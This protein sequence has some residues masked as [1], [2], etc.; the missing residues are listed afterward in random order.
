MMG[1]DLQ[2]MQIAHLDHILDQYCNLKSDFRDLQ[3]TLEA[4]VLD[5]DLVTCEQVLSP[6]I[7]QKLGDIHD[8]LYN[9][10]SG[11]T[12]FERIMEARFDNVEDHLAGAT[13]VG[14]RKDVALNDKRICRKALRELICYPFLASTFEENLR[15]L[16]NNETLTKENA[17]R[18]FSLPVLFFAHSAPQ[19]P[20]GIVNFETYILEGRS[21]YAWHQ[22]RLRECSAALSYAITFLKQTPSYVAS[23]CTKRNAAYAGATLAA[24]AIMFICYQYSAELQDLIAD[25]EIQ[26]G[27][28]YAG[29]WGM[30]KLSHGKTWC[31]SWFQPELPTCPWISGYLPSGLEQQFQQIPPTNPLDLLPDTCGLFDECAQCDPTEF[32]NQISNLQYQLSHLASESSATITQLQA[33][34]A[35]L[36]SQAPACNAVSCV[37]I[38]LAVPLDVLQQVA[39]MPLPAIQQLAQTADSNTTTQAAQFIMRSLQALKNDGVGLSINET[40]VHFDVRQSSSLGSYISSCLK[41]LSDLLSITA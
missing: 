15:E 5:D 40:L 27:I 39:S 36:T 21:A 8:K 1:I 34:I 22:K 9:A 18:L 20:N 33:Q 37:T 38:G 17:L 2:A 19:L 3:Q 14:K 10:L 41:K 35:T 11:E 12:L 6:L 24:I 30:E 16:E 29:S 26:E 28:R 13:L 25:Y 7:K 4:H 32:V 23:K 31:Q